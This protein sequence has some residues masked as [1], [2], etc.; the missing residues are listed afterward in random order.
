[1]NLENK[2]VLIVGGAAGIGQATA[3]LCT[4]R[5]AHVI[6][7][8]F[9]VAEGNRTASQIGG[10]FYP[11]NVAD[12]TS[13]KALFA[14]IAQ[15]HASIDALVQTAG[16]MKGSFVPLDELTAETFRQTL[17]INLIGSFLCAKYAA[18]L[19]RKGNKPVIVLL[20]SMAAVNGSSSYAYG[21]SKGGVSSL[22]YT[23]A[24]KLAPEGIRVNTVL[25]GNID[26]AMK[27]SVIQAE[28]ERV[29]PREQAQLE[30]GEPIGVARLLA[31][32]VSDDADYVRGDI[33][34]R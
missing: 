9:N 8:D 33:R 4:E 23:L 28:A 25:P 14:Q 18:P 16:V 30:L 27:R 1:M 17:D 34:T 7:A 21:A 20:S 15:R 22:G 6:I 19:L 26:T 32:L 29:G 13:V 3:H 31:F 11:I 5:G 12:E 2:T 10:E 24:N